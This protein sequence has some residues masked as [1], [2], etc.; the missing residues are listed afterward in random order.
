MCAY[1]FIDINYTTIQVLSNTVS[2]A[3]EV[4][5]KAET[6]KTAK[7]VDMFDKFFDCLNMSSFTAR[8]QS[9]NPF[10]SRYRK[11]TDFRLKL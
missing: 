2:K 7:L 11:D 9:R 5:S 6:E 8:I 4:R 1:I 3:M 10:K